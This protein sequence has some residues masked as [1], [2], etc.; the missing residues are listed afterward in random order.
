[1]FTLH[2]QLVQDTTEVCELPLCKVLL[3][4]DANYPWIILV[5]KRENVSEI[6]E[7]S[8]SDQQQLWA[9]SAHVSKVLQQLFDAD[10][11]NI[12]AL[13]NLVPQLHVHHIVRRKNDIAWPNPVWGFAP[14]K[15]YELDERNARLAALKQ[16][17]LKQ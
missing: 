6:I 13:G 17:L 9:E 7:L 14:A 2:P 12:A 5:P 11:L 4:N 15:A 1:M 3:S 16:A 10:K 8:D